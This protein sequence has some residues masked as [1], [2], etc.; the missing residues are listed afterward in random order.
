MSKDTAEQFIEW[1][2]GPRCETKDLDDFPEM[3]K[4]PLRNRC[5]CCEMWE[6]YDQWVAEAVNDKS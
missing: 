5:A 6:A 1:G 4:D 3:R 2:W